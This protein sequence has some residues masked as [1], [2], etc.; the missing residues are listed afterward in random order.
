MANL[1]STGAKWNVYVCQ[2]PFQLK[3]KVLFFPEAIS[4]QEYLVKKH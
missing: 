3:Q 4:N 2:V 1:L